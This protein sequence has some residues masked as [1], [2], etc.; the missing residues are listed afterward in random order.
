MHPSYPYSQA[1]ATYEFCVL[2]SMQNGL[3]IDTCV[4]LGVDVRWLNVHV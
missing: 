2:G 4:I 3:T 1:V